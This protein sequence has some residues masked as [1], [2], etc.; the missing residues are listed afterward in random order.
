[1]ET[2]A[3]LF[4][5]FLVFV[6]PELCTTGD[7]GPGCIQSSTDFVFSLS[8]W[9]VSLVLILLMVLWKSLLAHTQVC[10]GFYA[11]DE[12]QQRRA[13]A[14]TGANPFAPA[15]IARSRSISRLKIPCSA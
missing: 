3:K 4:E 6:Y 15:W 11:R 13:T 9:I 12:A 2:F 5:R 10:I 8:P 14:I 1:M 7:R